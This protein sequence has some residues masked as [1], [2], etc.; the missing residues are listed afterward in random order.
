MLNEGEKITQKRV[1]MIDDIIVS[2]RDDLKQCKE[3]TDDNEVSALIEVLQRNILEVLTEIRA[4]VLVS[5]IYPDLPIRLSIKD[6]PIKWPTEYANVPKQ[7]GLLAITGDPLYWGHI[8]IAL[9]A[10]VELDLDCVVIQIM[11]EHPHKISQK[12]PKEHRHAIA[13]NALEFF[14]PLLRYTPLGYDNLK[15]GEE[16]ASELLLLNYGLP[17]DLYY[18]AGGD[19]HDVAVANLA[20]CRTLLL[21][22]DGSKAPNLLGLFF[23]RE[24]EGVNKEALMRKYPFI[25]FATHKYEP[26]PKVRGLDFSSTMFRNDSSIPI[27]P[28]RAMQYIEKHGLYKESK[29]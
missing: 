12:Q 25:T 5:K 26:F 16:N 1:A 11:G 2:T 14:Y 27:L 21:P 24:S 20:A 10:I 29:I 15:I 19:V 7:I 9:C 13:R 23:S 6:A 28:T 18:I 22:R 4:R 8:F 17:I 3:R